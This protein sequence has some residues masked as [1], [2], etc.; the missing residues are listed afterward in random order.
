MHGRMVDCC[1]SGG[2]VRYVRGLWCVRAGG[3]YGMCGVCGVCERGVR[4][5]CAGYV[6]CAN[7]G[8]V[9]ANGRVV[10]LYFEL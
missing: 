9:S 4:A 10:L 8:C 3:A 5:V 6:V 7:G 1:A 2:C